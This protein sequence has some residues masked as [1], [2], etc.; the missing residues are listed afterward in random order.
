MKQRYSLEVSHLV[1]KDH[2]VL[3]PSFATPTVL[4]L[5]VAKE[6]GK[7]ML[8]PLGNTHTHDYLKN[9]INS[10]LYFIRFLKY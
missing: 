3:D 9:K 1:T 10:S 4:K 8:K 7:R 6:G 5:P 2:N